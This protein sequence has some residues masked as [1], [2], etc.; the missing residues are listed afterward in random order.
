MFLHGQAGGPHLNSFSWSAAMDH[1]EATAVMLPYYGAYY[2]PVVAEKLRKI[3]D[4]LGVRPSESPAA[5]FAEG[6]FSFYRT[7]GF[8]TALR[9]FPR[10]STA[11]IERA[12]EDG[13]N[14][15][16]KLAAMPRPVPVETSREILSTII[17]GAYHGKHRGYRAHMTSRAHRRPRCLS[18]IRALR[19]TDAIAHRR[20]RS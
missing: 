14:N 20:V 1:G 11:D 7:I 6:L 16:M 8:P 15:T 19:Y 9:E 5:D 2:A 10:F 4:L 13:C 17:W 3:A 18:G 12:V